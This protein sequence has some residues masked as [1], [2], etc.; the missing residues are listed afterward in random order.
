[1]DRTTGDKLKALN[2]TIKDVVLGKIAEEDIQEEEVE[3]LDELSPQTKASYRQKAAKNITKRAFAA[4][5]GKKTKSAHMD[6][7]MIHPAERTGGKVDPKVKKRAQGIGRAGGSEK[8]A[9]DAAA[10]AAHTARHM[11]S[12]PPS[13]DYGADDHDH[14]TTM[15]RI[16]MRAKR[17]RAA[18]EK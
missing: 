13:D 2:E 15:S 11:K 10:Q 16:H 3:Q 12:D 17:N 18:Q 1:M 8:R 7:G 6:R 4:A 9:R 5:A 14:H